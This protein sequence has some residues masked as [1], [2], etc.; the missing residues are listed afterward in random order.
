VDDPKNPIRSSLSRFEE[1]VF[2]C[3]VSLFIW[4][5]KHYI[6]PVIAIGSK[7][8]LGLYWYLVLFSWFSFKA[9]PQVMVCRTNLLINLSTVHETMQDLKRWRERW[10]DQANTKLKFSLLARAPTQ[11]CLWDVYLELIRLGRPHISLS[12]SSVITLFRKCLTPRYSNISLSQRVEHLQKSVWPV[13]KLLGTC[14]RYT[15]ISKR[16]CTVGCDARNGTREMDGLLV[17]MSGRVTRSRVRL[18]LVG[19]YYLYQPSVLYIS[20]QLL[21]YNKITWF[22]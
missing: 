11:G 12:F 1:P 20:A 3:S 17:V 21:L 2:H 19:Y 10:G 16:T 8:L 7:K 22:Y 14:W 15:Y 18:V 13:W 6:N 5:K 4:I 9:I